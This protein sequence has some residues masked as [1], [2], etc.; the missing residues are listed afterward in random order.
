MIAGWVG[1]L[2]LGVWI[3]LLLARGRFW[4]I[5]V[6]DMPAYNPTLP[7]CRI[8]V[9]VPARDEAPVIAR[10]VDSLLR[11]DYLGP[12]QIFLVDDHSS[13]NTADIAKC[14]AEESGNANRLTVIQAG[15]LPDGWTG[16]LWALSEGVQAASSFAPDYY[17][18]TDADVVHAADD[19]SSLFARAETGGFDLVSMM[20]KLRCESFAERMLIPAFVFFFF[21]LYPPRWVASPEK[22]TAAAAGGCILIRPAALTRAGGI[23]AIRDQLIDDCALARAVKREGGRI[24]LGLSSRAKSLREYGTF[25]EIGRMIAR[26]AFTQLN[27]STVLLCAVICAMAIT[28]LAPI[29][30]LG[31]GR[32]P[33]AFGLAAWLLMT[34]TYWPTVRWFKLSPRWAPL[35]PFTALFYL[36]ATIVSALQYWAGQGGVWKGRVQDL[37]KS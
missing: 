35:L 9:I 27:H 10:T 23:A 7:G 19:L 13:D 34:V 37:A 17:W 3:Y 14:A 25:Q 11:Q 8:A 12:V 22:R 33:A 1:A 2:S 30:L 5:K 15:P 6:E 24:S 16:K 21:K 31:S 26:S 18:F 29:V 32:W 36:G 28:Y 20:V 4:A